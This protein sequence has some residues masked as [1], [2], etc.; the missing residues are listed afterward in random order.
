M[1]YK[2]PLTRAGLPDRK[3]HALRHTAVMIMVVPRLSV[4]DVSR[5]LGQANVTLTADTYVH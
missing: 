1:N 3:F 4:V 5:I 2:Q